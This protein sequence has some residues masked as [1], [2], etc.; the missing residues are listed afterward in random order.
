MSISRFACICLVCLGMLLPLAAQTSSTGPE[1]TVQVPRLIR[2]S[3]TLNPPSPTSAASISSA[4]TVTFTSLASF[5]GTDGSG[6]NH[7]ALVQ[8]TDGN[9]YGTVYTGGAHGQ[10]AF[11]RISPAGTRTT[12]Y[13]FCSETSCADGAGPLGTLIQASN[14]DL[15]G[16]ASAGGTNGQGTFFRITTDGTLTTVYNFCS[17]TSCTDGASPEGPLIQDAAGNFYGTAYS[18][19]ANGD[20]TVFKITPSGTL[21]TL[22]SFNGTDGT[23][24]EGGVTEVN[25]VFYGT[26]NAGATEGDGTVFKMT[27][28]GVLTTLHIFTGKSDGD[29]SAPLGWL[30]AATNGNLYGTTTYGGVNGSGSVFEITLA[31]KETTLYSFCSLSSCADGYYGTAGL[32]QA[33]DGNLYGNTGYGGANNDGTTYKLTTAGVLTTLHSF[34]GTDG[35]DP[36]GGVM[37]DTNGDIYGMTLDGGADGDGTIFRLSVG[38]KPYITLR[39]T[40]GKVGSTVGIL[41]EGFDS[42]SEVKFN[43]VKATKVTL[44]GTA[45]LVATVPAGAT[46]GF[47]TVTTG[48]TTVTSTK[49]FDVLPTITKFAP[50]SGPVG[51]SVTITGTGL[52]QATKVTFDGKSTT[53]KVISETEVTADVPTGAT[54]GK[55]AVTTKGGSATSATSFTVN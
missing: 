5:D 6:P 37:Q 10:G 25:G 16:T 54:T 47:V 44:T 3:G 18:G 53:F 32:M 50:E 1:A 36:D 12:L 20:G 2:L 13:S 9:L 23:N 39:S 31:G 40:S 38:L 14:G 30:V 17:K 4:A 22:H 49:T 48:S 34:D 27:T 15:Y 7:T 42:A 28:A 29:G 19:G 52:T 33:T 35:S 55:I 46:T 51:T 41:G 26:T 8:A 45:Y 21:T 24:P 43:G 11:F